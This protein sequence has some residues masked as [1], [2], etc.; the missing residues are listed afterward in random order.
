M[1]FHDVYTLDAY[2][3]ALHR[4]GKDAEASKYATESLKLGSR[5]SQKLFRAGIIAKANGD[6]EAAFAYLEESLRL[7]PGFSILHAVEAKAALAAVKK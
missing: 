2:A 1:E 7:N 3:W 5:D 4:N 6:N